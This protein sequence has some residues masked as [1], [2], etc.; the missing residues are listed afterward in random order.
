MLPDESIYNILNAALA[1]I[2]VKSG[3]GCRTKRRSYSAFFIF[4]IIIFYI[5]ILAITVYIN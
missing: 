3:S 1:V 4:K 2:K 5:N